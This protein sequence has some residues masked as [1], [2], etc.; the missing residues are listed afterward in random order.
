[1]LFAGAKNA[2]SY[3]YAELLQMLL[4]EHWK[5][6][7]PWLFKLYTQHFDAFN[8]HAG[9]VSFGVIE[10]DLNSRKSDKASLNK[11]SNAYILT[12]DLH[13]IKSKFSSQKE[14]T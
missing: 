6:N 4:L 9:E 14:K 5:T 7:C 13:D 1:M 3:F 12:K 2:Y 11:R 10:G 8:E